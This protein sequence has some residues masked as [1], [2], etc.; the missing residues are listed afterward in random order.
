MHV[1]LND[2]GAIFFHHTMTTAIEAL[3]VSL[4]PVPECDSRNV[5]SASSPM[6]QSREQL[7]LFFVQ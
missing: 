7:D 4:H 1:E 3:R 6:Q 5:K 2:D